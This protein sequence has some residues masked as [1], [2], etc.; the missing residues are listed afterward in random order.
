MLCDPPP[1]RQAQ[2]LPNQSERQPM[3]QEMVQGRDGNQSARPIIGESR[4]S[5]Q[6]FEEE[7][8]VHHPI[9]DTHCRQIKNLQNTG[10]SASMCHVWPGV[11]WR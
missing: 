7:R 9:A 2:Q 11:P 3:M 5:G 1:W 8:G 4:A 10:A 6:A